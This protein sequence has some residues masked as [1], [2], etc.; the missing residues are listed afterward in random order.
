MEE[1]EE[2]NPTFGELRRALED[3]DH[4]HH[5]EALVQNAELSEQL[6]PIFD[7]WQKSIASA[8]EDSQAIFALEEQQAK[9]HEAMRGWHEQQRALTEQLVKNNGV[10]DALKRVSAPV[11]V[12]RA[13][14]GLQIKP[15]VLESSTAQPP[16]LPLQ[17]DK[18]DWLELDRQ[19]QRS[20]RA[21]AEAKAKARQ[22]QIARE[23]QQIEVLKVIAAQGDRSNHRLDALEIRATSIDQQ[24]K[25]GLEEAAASS[26]KA[27]RQGRLVL[28]VSVL[29]LL[30]AVTASPV[31]AYFVKAL[32]MAATWVSE[33]L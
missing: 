1:P 27:H 10:A 12:G 5:T 23:E 11:N 33:H 2:W 32:Q 4:P 6:R 19:M 20:T 13:L 9:I 16:V 7:K 15:P 29:T 14:D 31:G 25:A 26:Q 18:P 28:F 30:V 24:V 17:T 3:E 22:A 8:F 21:A